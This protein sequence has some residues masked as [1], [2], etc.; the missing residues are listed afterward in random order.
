M[1]TLVRNQQQQTQEPEDESKK[2]THQREHSRTK[3]NPNGPTKTKDQPLH[4]VPVLEH[5]SPASCPSVVGLGVD[6][7]T[8]WH[9]CTFDCHFGSSGRFCVGI[10]ARRASG[11]RCSADDTPQNSGSGRPRLGRRRAPRWRVREWVDGD[12]CLCNGGQAC[13]GGV[14]FQGICTV[15]NICTIVETNVKSLFIVLLSNLGRFKFFILEIVSGL[16]SSHV[17]ILT[18]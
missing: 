16:L 2:N 6:V 8:A 9:R 3:Q 7:F 11:V 1:K 15:C 18:N 14:F 4:L 13:G 17:Y 5:H 12:S 10:S